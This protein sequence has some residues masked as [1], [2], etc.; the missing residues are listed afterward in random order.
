MGKNL[1]CFLSTVGGCRRI[2]NG[3]IFKS[4]LFHPRGEQ[5]LERQE[6]PVEQTSKQA[7]VAQMENDGS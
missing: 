6:W 5:T 3:R 4:A 2:L 1:G 7:N